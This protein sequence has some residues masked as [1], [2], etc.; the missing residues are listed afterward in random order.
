LSNAR[1]SDSEIVVA[2]PRL[3][4]R[5]AQAFSALARHWSAPEP[6]NLEN[7]GLQSLG[8]AVASATNTGLAIELYL[9]TL[10]GVLGGIP[11]G[12]DLVALFDRL[13]PAARIQ[14]ER[15]YEEAL[16]NLPDGMPRALTVASATRGQAGTPE[17]K[18]PAPDASLRALLARSADIFVTWRYFHEQDSSLGFRYFTYEYDALWAAASALELA[19]ALYGQT[20]LR[21]D[22]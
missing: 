12:H 18:P 11:R 3:A 19:I 15:L 9:K 7:S 22:A 8:A 4:Y 6:A 14:T 2:D 20:W 17:G 13:P 5:S 21:L 16:R 10:H 1:S